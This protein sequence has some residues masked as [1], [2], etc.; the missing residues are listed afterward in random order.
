M[1]T[2]T[3]AYRSSE[4][5]LPICVS[6]VKND[7]FLHLYVGFVT[8]DMYVYF[9]TTANDP[10]VFG[11]YSAMKDAVCSPGGTTIQGVRTLEKNGFRSAAMEAVIAAYEKTMELQRK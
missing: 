4:G 5:W 1:I 8:E 7:A 9:I 6:D 10:D 3:V 11:V 2:R